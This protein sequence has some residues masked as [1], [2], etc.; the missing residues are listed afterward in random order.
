MFISV[1]LKGI[2]S[3]IRSWRVGDVKISDPEEVET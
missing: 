2:I 1:K 3:F